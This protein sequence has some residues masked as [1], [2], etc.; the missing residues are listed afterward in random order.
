MNEFDYDINQFWQEKPSRRYKGGGGGS[1][2]NPNIPE[3]DTSR[4]A[5]SAIYPSVTNAIEGKGFGTAGFQAQRAESFSSG[6]AKSYNRTK[7][8]FDS[9]MARTI[10]PRDTRVKNF[11]GNL[12]DN[13]FI[14]AK[15]DMSRNLRAEKVSDQSVGL[16]MGQQMLSNEQRIG[17]GNAQSYN[18]ALAVS[19]SNA[20]A[21]GT[22]GTNVAAGMGQ[23]M[24]DYLFA[25]KM[26]A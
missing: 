12:M 8:D 7:S 21:M 6:L 11:A 14:T 19:M 26:G 20:Q 17:V 2:P 5:K 15:D 23:G 16:D 22:F 25:Q 9:N 13:A 1:A 10:D 3:T 4:W 24:T 18:N